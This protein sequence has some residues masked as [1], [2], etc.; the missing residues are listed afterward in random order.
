MT[1]PDLDNVR[2]RLNRA[3][4]VRAVGKVIGACGTVLQVSGVLVRIGEVCR[5]FDPHGGW[6][7]D[8][9]VVGL[10]E[11]GALL[12]P[13]GQLRGMTS[14]ARVATLG[15]AASV[16]VGDAL[17]GRVIDA[18]GGPIDGAGPMRC[19]EQAQ[20]YAEP[21]APMRRRKI[22]QPLA[23]GVR[24][25]DSLLACG[26]GQRVG[27]FAPAGAGKSTLLGM[28]SRG[29]DADV[30]VVALIGERGREV[31]EFIEQNLGSCLHKTVVVAATSDAPPLTKTRAMCAATAIAEYFRDRGARVLLMVDSLTRYAR[32]LRDVG[33]AAG[34]PPTRQGFPPSVFSTLPQLLERAGNGEQ[35]S[36]S[37]FY[38]I[39]V[40]DD[41]QTDPVAEEARSILDG[42]I[43]LSR[44]LA[45][46]NHYPAIDVLR[47]ASR[48]MNSLVSDEHAAT[49]AL[50]RQRLAKFDEI[51]LLMQMGEY[52]SGSDPEADAAVASAPNLRA[53]LVQGVGEHAPADR[54]MWSLRQA[55]GEKA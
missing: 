52:E 26:V 22:A 10:T 25:I 36:I 9:E 41:E 33:L 16:A 40:E 7:L 19:R 21:P 13:F 32:A 54:S 6:Q 48:L 31:R 44:K 34:E 28:L 3:T 50:A 4:S 20:L 55:L 47:S 1:G 38:T 18:G 14:R 53:H 5:L 24:A 35:G 37:A 46:K 11:T 8:A 39:L 12:V 42:H 2:E 15:H 23:T 17:L 29:V 30:N 49:A 45:A 51:E 27:I 43:V